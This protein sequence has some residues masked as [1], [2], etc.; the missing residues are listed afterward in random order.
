LPVPAATGGHPPGKRHALK[1]SCEIITHQLSVNRPNIDE[2]H[3]IAAVVSVPFK[4]TSAWIL[5]ARWTSWFALLPLESPLNNPVFNQSRSRC[6][7]DRYP[8]DHTLIN[9]RIEGQLSSG[10]C[11]ACEFEL[12]RLNKSLRRPP[13]SSDVRV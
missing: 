9:H 13:S 4:K 1:P 10:S 12:Q 6:P 8:L 11:D 5:L 2:R 3:G 7:G